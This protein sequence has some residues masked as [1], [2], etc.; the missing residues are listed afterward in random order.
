[1]C[2]TKGGSR[3]EQVAWI[4]LKKRK[5]EDHSHLVPLRKLAEG[6]FPS[7]VFLWIPKNDILPVHSWADHLE[8]H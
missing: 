6:V 3:D 8:R 4:P 5:P 7:R 2:G 1:M